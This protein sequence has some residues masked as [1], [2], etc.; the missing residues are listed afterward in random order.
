MTSL[1][2]RAIPLFAI[3]IRARDGIADNFV[4]MRPR[5][6]HPVLEIRLPRG[7]AGTG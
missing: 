6:S 1:L 2:N 5:R 3:Q 7:G 4:Q